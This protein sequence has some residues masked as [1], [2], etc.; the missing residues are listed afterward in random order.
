M[1]L[2]IAVNC[3]EGIVLAA[4]SRATLPSS[5]GWPEHLDNAQKVFSLGKDHN[6]VGGLIFGSS[7]IGGRPVQSW[8]TEIEMKPPPAPFTVNQY[9]MILSE[10][11]Y[12]H[13]ENAGSDPEEATSFLVAG[14][15]P[16]APYG[17]IFGFSIPDDP[18]PI[19]RLAQFGMSWGGQSNV[20]RRIM[21]GYDPMLIAIVSK[22]V[23]LTTR[24]QRDALREDLR[25][26]HRGAPF[27]L[28]SLQDCIDFATSLISM[29]A[30]AQQ[31]G[32]TTDQEL[33]AQ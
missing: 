3:P 27:S 5:P 13:W 21:F 12:K 9:A 33:V 7:T 19:R 25:Q 22:H 15:D 23:G 31:M 14:Y 26:L 6:W 4:D 17:S 1:S 10:V 11:F 8:L 2:V 20:I 30:I 32:I 29:T 18:D 24:P 28:F 16:D